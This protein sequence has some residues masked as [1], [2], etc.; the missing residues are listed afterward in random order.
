MPKL[1]FAT[2]RFLSLLIVFYKGSIVKPSFSF[3]QFKPLVLQA[4]P[5]AVVILLMTIYTRI[6]AVMLD[7]LLP[8]TGA[9]QG[10]YAGIPFVRCR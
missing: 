6:D 5:Y 2:F 4:M 1:C 9:V 7:K 10:I 8:N 3:Q